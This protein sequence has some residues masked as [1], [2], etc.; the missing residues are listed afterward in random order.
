M[1][2]TSYSFTAVICTC[3]H[4]LAVAKCIVDI[5]NAERSNNSALVQIVILICTRIVG[6]S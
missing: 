2:F 6:I 1:S 3:F 4:I 5:D